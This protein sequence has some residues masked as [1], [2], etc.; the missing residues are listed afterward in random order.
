MKATGIVR[1]IDDLGRIVIPKEM[2]KTLHIHEG[3]A[4]EIFIEQKGEIIL[5]KY[6]PMNDFIELA[7]NYANALNTVT[8]FEVYITDREN[9]I[10]SSADLKNKNDK[11]IGKSISDEVL[12]IMKERKSLILKDSS[13]F[14]LSLDEKGKNYASVIISNIITDAEVI[15][16]IILISKDIKASSYHLAIADIVAKIISTQVV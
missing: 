5:K 9:I 10:S 15:G 4:L 13:N 7:S 14:S 2:R 11:Y 3:D 16:S 6:T 1:K 12:E 8:S